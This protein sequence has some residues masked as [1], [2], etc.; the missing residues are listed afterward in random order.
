MTSQWDEYTQQPSVRTTQDGTFG[1][2]GE[3]RQ[4]GQLNKDNKYIVLVESQHNIDNS[5]IHKC[6][7]LIRSKLVIHPTWDN[8]LPRCALCGCEPLFGKELADTSFLCNN[9][10]GPRTGQPIGSKQTNMPYC[11]TCETEPLSYDKFK[12]FWATLNNDRR[13]R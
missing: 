12:V 3:K 13:G 1:Y 2:F 5:W 11:P 7:T 6:G 9:C 4:G 10:L 8:K